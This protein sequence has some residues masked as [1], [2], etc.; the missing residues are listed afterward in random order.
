MTI[1][2]PMTTCGKK[3]SRRNLLRIPQLF[4]LRGSIPKVFPL[5]FKKKYD[6]LAVVLHVLQNAQILVT[7]HTLF[8]SERQ[9]KSSRCGCFAKL[10]PFMCLLYI[11]CSIEG[12][13]SGA[14]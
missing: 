7:S 13:S 10:S 6:K 1:A 5:S 2:T 9:K 14:N 4:S 3:K 8:R 12:T 11:S